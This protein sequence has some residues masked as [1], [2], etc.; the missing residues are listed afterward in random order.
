MFSGIGSAQ[1]LGI[2]TMTPAASA[3]LDIG[4]TMGG[5]LPLGLSIA[6][7]DAIPSPA[8]V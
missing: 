5:F 7:R 2:G 8:K 6:Q 1:G 4:P 3:A